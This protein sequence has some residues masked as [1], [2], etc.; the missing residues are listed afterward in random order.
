MLLNHLPRI[1][2]RHA[3]YP[4]GTHLPGFTFFLTEKGRSERLRNLL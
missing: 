1:R 4:A 3:P 2:K